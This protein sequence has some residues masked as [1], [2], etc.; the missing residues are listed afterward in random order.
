MTQEDDGNSSL[1]RRHAQRNH[2]VGQD[3]ACYDAL[4]PQLRW[5]L[6]QTTGKFSAVETLF[7]LHE[8]RMPIN[9]L[10]NAVLQ[11]EARELYYFAQ[12]HRAETGY[13]YPH[14]A[15]HATIMRYGPLVHQP[16]NRPKVYNER[17]RRHRRIRPGDISPELV[18]Y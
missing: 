15:A 18:D 6:M 13:Q 1:A 9:A 8:Q 14:V 11:A 12:Q 16:R 4:P 5:I 17:N 2:T 10:I 3:F 7:A